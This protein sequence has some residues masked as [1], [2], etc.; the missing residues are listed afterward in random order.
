MNK[1]YSSTLQSPSSEQVQKSRYTQQAGPSVSPPVY[2]MGTLPPP[3]VLKTALKQYGLTFAPEKVKVL[4]TWV[5]ETGDLMR[6]CESIFSQID[7]LAGV[8]VL[9]L[10]NLP[11]LSA[12]IMALL[13]RHQLICV[14]LQYRHNHQPNYMSFEFNF[15]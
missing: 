9:V 11:I 5:D 14:A 2:V 3:E 10:P 12:A 6:Q 4:Y 7:T 1:R 8:V 15:D 13:S